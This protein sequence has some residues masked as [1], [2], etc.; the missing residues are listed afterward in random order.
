MHAPSIRFPACLLGMALAGGMTMAAAQDQPAPGSKSAEGQDAAAQMS[1]GIRN[2]DLINMHG[3]HTMAATVVHA[4]AKTGLVDV[5]A[6]GMALRVH[7]PP[8]AMASL[9]A[10][11]K[12]G[13]YMGYSQASVV[14]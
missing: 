6:E 8:A 13:L 12:I 10:G 7:F 9:K 3:M 14:K 5:M 2:D 11:D 1:H 4:D